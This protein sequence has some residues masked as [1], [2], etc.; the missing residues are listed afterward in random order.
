MADKSLK[1]GVSSCFM[2]PDM[3]RPTFGPKTLCFYE[4][5][6]ARYLTKT[7]IM[8][9]LIPDVEDSLV[10]MYFAQIDG[11]VLQGGSDVSPLSYNAALIENGRWPGDKYRDDYEMKLI[12]KAFKK[13]IPV[14][15]ICRGMQVLNVFFG[16]SLYQDIGLQVKDALRHRDAQEYDKVKHQVKLTGPC[17]RR[18]YDSDEIISVNS[19][20]HQAV[21]NL[22]KGLVPEAS[23]V[24][25]NITEAFSYQ[26]GN[27]FALGV[28]W[29]PEFSPTLGDQ[30]ADPAKIYDFFIDKVKQNAHS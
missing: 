14:L 4:R 25:D 15:G 7:D 10:D 2:Y 9:V 20:H 21:Q 13:N 28:Q 3:N 12:E 26:E 6:M 16:G 11:F 5:D 17:L 1:I 8:T 19:V 24:A 23:S 30:V 22:G 18:I 29:H 27:Q